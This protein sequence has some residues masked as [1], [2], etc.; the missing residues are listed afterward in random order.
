MIFKNRFDAGEK[1]ALEFEEYKN[2][3]Q[4]LVVAVPRGGVEV[5]FSFCQKLCLPMEITVARKIGTP[6]SSELA[7]GAVNEEGDII[8][9][10]S[11]LETYNVGQ[12]YLESQAKIEK[13]E[14]EKRIKKYRKKPLADFK[15]KKVIIIDD[16]I[17]T[18]ATMKAIIKMFKKKKVKELI[19]AV[20]VASPE[21]LDE[22]RGS[23]QRIVCLESPSSFQAVGQFYQDFKQV[24]DEEVIQRLN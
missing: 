22:I 23:C 12:D 1:L 18:G 5:A 16:G 10:D 3:S 24:T 14:I 4:A 15:D 17:A 11:V 7:L 19:V 8:V 6:F 2:D 13:Q 20:P 21:A 9:N